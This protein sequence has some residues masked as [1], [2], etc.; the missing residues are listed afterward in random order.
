FG[1]AVLFAARRAAHGSPTPI[2]P[3]PYRSS[4]QVPISSLANVIVLTPNGTLALREPKIRIAAYAAPAHP[5]AAFLTPPPP[6]D[7]VDTGYAAR[8]DRATGTI[9]ITAP[10]AGVMAVG[11]YRF[12]ER[13]LQEWARRLGPNAML[14]ALPDHLSGHRLAG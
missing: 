6:P 14:T 4:P 12:P 13:D 9:A 11:G 1:E 3:G 8:I 2:M 5:S 7:S 10:T